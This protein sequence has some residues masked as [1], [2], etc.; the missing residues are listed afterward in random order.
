MRTQS[1]GSAER[2]IVLLL[3]LVALLLIS[4]VAAS[5]LYM[6][7]TE[8]TMVGYQRSN[9][10][11][12]NA[13]RGGLEEGRARLSTA[14]PS[15]LGGATFSINFP[16]AAGEVL[17]I[18]NRA[19]G[20]TIELA[21]IRNAASPFYDWEYDRE[22]GAGALAAATVVN[23]TAPPATPLDSDMEALAG[24]VTQPLPEMQYKWIRVTILTEQAANRDINGDGVLDN[25][26]PVTWDSVT[27]RMNILDGPPGTLVDR[28]GDGFPESALDQD[29]DGTVEPKE[30]VGRSV[31]RVTALARQASTGATRLLQYDVSAPFVNL[32]FP[33]AVSLIGTTAACGPTATCVYPTMPDQCDAPTNFGPSNAMDSHGGDQA[34]GDGDGVP[35]NP[36]DG[37]PAIGFT[38]PVTQA[39]CRKELDKVMATGQW[40]GTDGTSATGTGDITTTAGPLATTSGLQFLINSIGA[41][42]DNV[43]TAGDPP[44]QTD[45]VGGNDS[46]IPPPGVFGQC[47]GVNQPKVTVFNGDVFFDAATNPGGCGVLLV[48]GN[49]RVQGNWNWK[50]IILVLGEGVFDGGGTP[51]MQGAQVVARMYCQ[52]GDP[53]PCPCG[54]GPTAS[55]PDAPPGCQGSGVLA[56]PYGSVFKFN[57]GGA[58]GWDYNSMFINNAFGSGSYT[59]LA[60]REIG[61]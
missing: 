50:G 18:R 42:A 51:S 46:I 3:A 32:N 49:L 30:R 34:D 15:F 40:T 39:D 11:V 45:G 12:F 26:I 22:W 31:Y 24:L 23:P 19:A 33:A 48:T 10:R 17:Y 16:D 27:N 25:A 55:P 58:G 20:E 8:S 54:G 52:D 37:G 53:P 47:N 41:V 7:A 35:D 61:R 29:L 56:G 57:G 44:P 43:F 36:T 28:D 6:T 4:A 5:L 59:V 13:A 1:Q 14:D 21:D 2:G 38:D 60:Y 9:T